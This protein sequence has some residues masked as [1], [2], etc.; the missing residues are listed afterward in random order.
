MLHIK[1]IFNTLLRHKSS[2]LL[3]ILQ[4]ALTFAVVVNAISIIQ[5]RLSDM[6]RQTGLAEN[7]LLAVNINPFGKD[8]NLKQNFIEDR[9]LVRAIPGVIDATL[10]DQLPLSGGGNSSSMAA[11]QEKFDNKDNINAGIFLGDNHLVHTLGVKIIAGRDFSAEE[12]LYSTKAE[13]PRVILITQTVADKLFP[14][15]NAL[16]KMVYLWGFNVRVIGIIEKMAGP[17]VH[18]SRYDDNV[19]MPILYLGR[20]FRRLLIRVKTSQMNE[21]L[22]TIE[23]KL[24]ARNPNRVIDGIRS[25]K[26]YKTGSYSGDRAMSK[27]LWYV[28]AL[29]IIITA[30]GIVGISSFNV[31]QRIKQ[32]GTRRALGAT[33]TDILSYFIT[34]NILISVIGV[35]LGSVIAV[36]FNI[37]IVNTFKLSAIEWYYF[38]VGIF[39]MLITGIVA[40]WAPAVKASRISPAVATQSV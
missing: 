2:S 14:K 26:E 28:V 20:N 39:I 21:L 6:H 23:K 34:E 22:G 12:V 1:P 19:L 24:L 35:L 7:Q 32:I 11:T 33:T 17:W 38:P 27:I 16:G 40:V 4:I 18:S 25:I 36:A 8:Y 29:L 9:A 30:L 15:G 37:Y 31:S 13:N 3:T 5:Q 10:I